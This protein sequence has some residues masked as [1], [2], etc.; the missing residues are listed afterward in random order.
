MLFLAPLMRIVLQKVSQAS[1]EVDGKPVAQIGPGYVLLIGILKGDT[2]EYGA[3]LAKK[4]AS[5]RLFPRED[6]KINDRNIL[7]AEGSVLSISQFTLAGEVS[8]GNRPDYT[9]AEEPGKA[10]AL[11]ESF[12]QE[13]RSAGIKNVA[14]GIFG[15]TMRV[16]L[17][18][19]GPVTLVLDRASQ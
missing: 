10:R 2:Q 13:L 3:W 15:A 8:K 9:T 14:T 7:E 18:N 19:D 4:I 6:G 12:C 17:L 5:L 11:Y 16:N 1:V